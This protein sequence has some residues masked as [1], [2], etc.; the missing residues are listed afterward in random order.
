MSNTDF[1]VDTNALTSDANDF[2]TEI[3]GIMSQTTKMYE[4]VQNLNNMWKG[5]AN[6]AFRAQFSQDYEK[7]TKFLEDLRNFAQTLSDDSSEY[8][9]CEASV[10][11]L[12]GGI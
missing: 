8:I 9:S 7:A 10:S 2:L 1:K 12:V 3:N 5:K 11:S 4:D 6:D